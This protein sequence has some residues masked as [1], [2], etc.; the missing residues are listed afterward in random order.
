MRKRK[1]QKEPS[2]SDTKYKIPVG[3][4]AAINQ[5]KIM[6]TNLLLILNLLKDE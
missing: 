6:P 5:N 3:I 4:A 1:N 2:I